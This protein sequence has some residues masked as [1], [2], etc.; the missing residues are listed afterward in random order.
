M[1]EIRLIATDM[2][3]T[4]LTSDKRMPEELPQ[5]LHALRERGVSFA[6]AS[7]RQYDALKRDFG[8]LAQD[9]V[10]ISENGAL[11]VENDRRLFIDPVETHDLPGI[12]RAGRGLRGVY[13]VVCRAGAALVEATASQAFIDEMKM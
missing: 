11:V 1:N 6:V 9:M 13:A 8:D 2:D 4:L 7:G 12:I 3:G 10:F 5:V